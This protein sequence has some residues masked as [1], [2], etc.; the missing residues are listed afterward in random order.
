ME[1][2]DHQWFMVQVKREQQRL[3]AWVRSLGVRADWVDDLAQDTFVVAAGKLGEFDRSKDFGAWLRGIARHLVINER[4][5]ESRRTRLLSE[6]MTAMLAEHAED[7]AA[8]PAITADDNERREALRHCLDQLSE[9]G[10]QLIQERYFEDLSAT[11][12]AQRSRRNSNEIRQALLRMR[13]NLLQC[14]Q[15]QLR[16]A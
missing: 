11:V 15:H 7:S 5:K 6:Q 16:E 3:R 12:I 8:S 10:R 4:R 14:M 13:R 1:Q 2:S 9:D